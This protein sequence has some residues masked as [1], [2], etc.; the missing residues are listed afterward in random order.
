LAEVF[1]ALVAEFTS[2]DNYKI[3]LEDQ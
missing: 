2:F 3:S 1:P